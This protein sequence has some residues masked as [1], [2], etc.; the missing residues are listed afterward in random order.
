MKN[1]IFVVG[2]AVLVAIFFVVGFTSNPLFAVSG[3]CK[4]RK[5]YKGGWS[6]NGKSFA[7]CKKLNNKDRDDVFDESGLYWWD[8]KC[9]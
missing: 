3:C 8:Q 6:K 2:L 4:E 5:S 7:A 9:R 1:T